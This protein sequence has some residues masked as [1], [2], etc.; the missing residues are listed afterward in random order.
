[1]KEKRITVGLDA[2][3]F[4]AFRLMCL[5]TGKSG[6]ELASQAIVEFIARQGKGGD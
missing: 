4:R 2:E 5:D 3:T 6:Q 1:M